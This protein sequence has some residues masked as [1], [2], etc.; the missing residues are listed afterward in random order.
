MTVTNE[1]AET[2]AGIKVAFNPET[3]RWDG[4]PPRTYKFALGDERGMGW[5][6]VT[7]N[8]LGG[9]ASMPAGFE[10]RYFEF[11]RDGYSSLEKHTHVHLIVVIRGKGKALVGD[12]VFDIN[13][14]DAIYVPPN[15]PHRWMNDGAEPFGFLCPVDAERDHPVPLSDE[16]WASLEANPVTA[17]YIF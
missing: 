11:A 16:E 2:L 17:P 9:A 3:F 8:T 1:L 10:F 13:P 4:V 15:T 6:G 7:R 5:K 12:R 14:F